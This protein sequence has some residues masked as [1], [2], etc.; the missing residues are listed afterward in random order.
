MKLHLGLLRFV[1]AFMYGNTFTLAMSRRCSAN[2]EKGSCT[3]PSHWTPQKQGRPLEP[4][5]LGA[6]LELPTT[7]ARAL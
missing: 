7:R 4:P 2:M 6:T 1:I 3:V 5:L